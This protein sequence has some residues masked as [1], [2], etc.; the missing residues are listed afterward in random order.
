MVD[1]F[2]VDHV[3]FSVVR[4]SLTAVGLRRVRAIPRAP[5]PAPRSPQ[6]AGGRWKS[7]PTTTRMSAVGFGVE[8]VVIDSGDMRKVETRACAAPLS[9]VSTCT[10]L[11]R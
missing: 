7:W 9:W 8:T 4:D 3:V 1:G 11:E 6:V 2:A 5:L 10:K